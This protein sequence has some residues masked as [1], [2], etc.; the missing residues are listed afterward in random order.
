VWDLSFKRVSSLY[1][2]LKGRHD[3]LVGFKPTGWTHSAR[4][5]S[6]KRVVT[7]GNHVS[8]Y[9]IPYSEHSSVN[10]LKELVA[11]LKPKRILPTVGGGSRE[12]IEAI[13]REVRKPKKERKAPTTLMRFFP[14]LASKSQ[15]TGVPSP[16]SRPVASGSA[17]PAATGTQAAKEESP[18]REVTWEEAV[19]AV[20]QEECGAGSED[21]LEGAIGEEEAQAASDVWEYR[22]ELLFMTSQELSQRS[23]EQA[24][25][26][27]VR[28]EHAGSE[29]CPARDVSEA[30][31]PGLFVSDSSEAAPEKCQAENA[32]L[33]WS[34]PRP[35]LLDEDDED[36]Q[37]RPAKACRPAAGV[38]KQLTKKE[39]KR[40]EAVRQ[41]GRSPG[42]PKIVRGKT[43]VLSFFQAWARPCFDDLA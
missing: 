11:W 19:L 10:E 27:A 31:A 37:A 35:S 25:D 39:W 30:E 9:N 13:V 5:K 26:A 41:Q 20:E 28:D 42:T 38:Q 15:A 2:R 36:D 18:A 4:Q 40:K 33:E 1:C 34:Q 32:V 22:A 24:A 43:S 21:G 23:Q 16:V 12:K 3:K 6:P 17:G 7:L 29:D 14:A 8:V